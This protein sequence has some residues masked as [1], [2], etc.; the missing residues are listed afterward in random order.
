MHTSPT[1]Q[2]RTQLL[3]LRHLTATLSDAENPEAEDAH[4]LVLDEDLK[5]DLEG[6]Q[7]EMD[8][9]P[10]SLSKIPSRKPSGKH[11]RIST[12]TASD[13]HERYLS[14]EEEPSPS[15]D[16]DHEDPDAQK[17]KGQ[18]DETA[19][20]HNDETDE[21]NTTEEFGAKVAIAVPILALGRPKL[22]DITNLAPM[23]KRKRSAEKAILRTTIKHKTTFTAVE[24]DENAPFVTQEAPKIAPPQDYPPR[25]EES[26]PDPAPETW[27]P[28]ECVHIVHEGDDYPP[29]LELRQALT[30]SDYDPFSLDPPRLSPRNSYSAPANNKGSVS[31]ARKASRVPPAMSNHPAFK[32]LG[33]SLSMAKK[34]E[35]QHPRGAAKKPKMLARAANERDTPSIPGFLL[36]SSIVK[37]VD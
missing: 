11:L 25:P 6:L 22:V 18:S 31:R 10:P 5:E 20:P 32:G 28:E 33:R 1:L 29:Q 37:E 34:Q 8:F 14:S 17:L 19:E 13:L 2:R 3:P 4:P 23:H 27:L 21:P 24:K 16:T 7:Q 35:A 26:L 15:P 30:Y 9:R 12:Y 36:N